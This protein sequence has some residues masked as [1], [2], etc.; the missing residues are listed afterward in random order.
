MAQKGLLDLGFLEQD[1]LADH[2]IELLD[3]ELAGHG[4]LVL[5]GSVEV[6]GAGCAHE[7]DF[8]T[9]DSSLD[10]L[11]LGAQRRHNGLNTQLVDDTHALAGHTDTHE[12]LLAFQP[13]T[14]IVQIRLETTLGLD[15]RV[16]NIVTDDGTLP[17][18]L[19]NLGHD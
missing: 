5:V 11:A 7:A 9:H 10:L 16:G 17:G 3:L 18:N 14:V 12:A 4:A 2:G 6:A 13:E 8:V 19:A 1:M 15:V